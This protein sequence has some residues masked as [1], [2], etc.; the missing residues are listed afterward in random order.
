[1]PCSPAVA[2]FAKVIDSGKGFSCSQGEKDSSRWEEMIYVNIHDGGTHTLKPPTLPVLA[3]TFGMAFAQYVRHP[4]SKSLGP[5]GT[6]YNRDTCGQLGRYPVTASGIHLIGKETERGWEQSEDIS[7]LLPSLLR[8]QESGV[9]GEQIRQRLRQM[10]LAFLERETGMS[11][12]TIVRVRTGQNVRA[13][14]LR[15]ISKTVA[16]GVQAK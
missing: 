6:P 4:E 15:M 14:S 10:P 11:R 8:Y 13:S 12:H 16:D 7:T 5:N 3:Q 2:S 9:V 1:M